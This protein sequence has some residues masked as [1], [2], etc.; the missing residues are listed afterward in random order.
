MINTNII[1]LHLSSGQIY[2]LNLQFCAILLW[3]LLIYCKT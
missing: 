1:P 2:D 3:R